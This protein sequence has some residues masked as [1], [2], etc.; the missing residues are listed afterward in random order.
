MRPIKRLV[1]ASMALTCV[2]ATASLW[3]DARPNP[4]FSIVE[5]NPFGIKPPPPLPPPDQ[6]QAAAPLAKVVLTGVTSMFGPPR[7]LLEITESEPGKGPTVNKRIL[8]E[9]DRDGSIEILAIDVANTSVRIKNGPVETNLVFEVAKAGPGTPGGFPTPPP[10]QFVPPIPGSPM[11]AINPNSPGAPNTGASPYI[12]SPGGGGRAGSGVTLTG[13]TSPATPTTAN[14]I[15]APGSFPNLSQPTVQTVPPSVTT[16][17]AGNTT[18]GTTT[19]VPLRNT[20]TDLIDAA[21]ARG[22]PTYPT[23]PTPA[24]PP[25][26]K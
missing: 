15:P 3:A 4:Y 25:Q 24:Y 1:F 22:L 6:P 12:V 14:G 10:H 13:A 8:R 7:A 5:R 11:G 9:G 18:P 23:Y 16:Y 19:T 26:T 21:K 2:G 17:G 20:R